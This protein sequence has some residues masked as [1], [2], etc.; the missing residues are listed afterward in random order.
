MRPFGAGE[1]LPEIPL[2]DVESDLRPVAHR[3]NELRDALDDLLFGF[4]DY[5]LVGTKPSR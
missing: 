1:R 5:A 3:V 2:G 4:Q